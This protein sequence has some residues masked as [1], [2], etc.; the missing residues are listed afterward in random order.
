MDPQVLTGVIPGKLLFVFLLFVLMMPLYRS[1]C[2]SPFS[3]CRPCCR[4]RCI[5]RGGFCVLG[6]SLTIWISWIG[7]WGLR[8]AFVL[9][10]FWWGLRFSF[11]WFFLLSFLLSFFPFPSSFFWSCGT[12]GQLVRFIMVDYMKEMSPSAS[13]EVLVL[14][15]FWDSACAL[16]SF[17]WLDALTFRPPSP[18]TLSFSVEE[19]YHVTFLAFLNNANNCWHLI[20]PN[21]LCR[22]LWCF[23]W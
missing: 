15:R 14:P 2:L 12:W 19:R 7:S 13:V 1:A 22:C 4:G 3:L 11:L 21:Y 10:L 20:I 17:L 9:L 18:P 8:S 16:A 5:V 23:A 6:N